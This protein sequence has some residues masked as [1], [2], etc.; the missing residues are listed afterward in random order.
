LPGGPPAMGDTFSLGSGLPVRLAALP[1]CLAETLLGHVSAAVVPI[2][3]DWEVD[4]ALDLRLN[5]LRHPCLVNWDNP[6][7]LQQDLLGVY[8]VLPPGA[9]VVGVGNRGLVNQL[10]VSL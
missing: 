10:V 2:G 6:L 3:A 1:E 4:D 7:V 5:Q 9:W 8:Q